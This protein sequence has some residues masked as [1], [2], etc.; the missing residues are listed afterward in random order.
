MCMAR[1]K[2]WGCMQSP[3]VVFL[4]TIKM[5]KPIYFDIKTWRELQQQKNNC[6]ILH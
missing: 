3:T 2:E 1:E 5:Q 4:P 6:S